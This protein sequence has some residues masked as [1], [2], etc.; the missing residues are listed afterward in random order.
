MNS[1]EAKQREKKRRD[2]YRVRYKLAMKR[3][4]Y[5]STSRDAVAVLIKKNDARSRKRQRESGGEA[6]VG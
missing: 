4:D 2:C 3:C 1:M 5:L 6:E